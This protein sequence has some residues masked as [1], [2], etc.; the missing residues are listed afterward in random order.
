MAFLGN[1][2]LLELANDQQ[3]ITPFDEKKIKN[4]AYELALGSEVYL[5]DSKTK[6]IEVL[7]ENNR[8]ITINPGQF[9]LLLTK[10]TIKVPKKNIAFISIKA[11]VKLKGLIN[12]SGFHVDPGFHD[13]LLFSV[14]NAGPSPITLYYGK[15]YFL[16]WLSEFMSELEETEIY[17]K[18]ND[19]FG[20]FAQIPTDYIDCLKRGEISSPNVL[21][22]KI[23]VIRANLINILWVAGVIVTIVITMFIKSLGESSKFNEG[24]YIGIKETQARNFID[25]VAF[26]Y[27]IDS[28]ISFKLDSLLRT[29]RFVVNKVKK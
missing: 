5:T 24:Y 12:V 9:A 8:D 15:P 1:K 28:I 10:E 19:H 27:K 3:F 22:K 20:K 21:L 14:Y 7:N 17:N 23:K 26:K 18:D 25:S 16:I 13:H 6:K 4:G 2:E 29:K 11:G